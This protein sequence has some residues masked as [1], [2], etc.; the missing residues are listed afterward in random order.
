MVRMPLRGLRG[1]RSSIAVS[2]KPPAGRDW[3]AASART[4]T[5]V[6]PLEV[7]SAMYPIAADIHKIHVTRHHQRQWMAIVIC[8]CRCEGFWNLTNSGFFSL[9]LGI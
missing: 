1:V 2:L 5:G 6:I 7:C 9:G 8:P 4:Q 3:T